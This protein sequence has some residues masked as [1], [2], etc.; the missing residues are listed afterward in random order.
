MDMPVPNKVERVRVVIELESLLGWPVP[1]MVRLRKG[2]KIL[3]RSVGFKA[4]S[5]VE[6]D[7]EGNPVA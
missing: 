7:Q 2:M 1:A 4:I 5:I 6:V 3:L